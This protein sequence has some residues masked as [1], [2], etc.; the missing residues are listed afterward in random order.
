[1]DDIVSNLGLGFSVA[2][3]ANNLFFAFIGCLLGTL[4]GVLPGI[5][6]SATIAILLPITYT[7]APEA[8][9]IMMAGIY[10]G[11]QYGGSTTAIMIKLPGESS[12]IVTC[13][14]GYAMT[15]K[16]RSGPA[17]TAA[18]ISS[19]A[20]GCFGIAILILFAK[21]LTSLVFEFGAAEYFALMVLG[22]VGAV[23][24]SSSSGLSAIGMVIVGLLLGLVGTDVNTGVVR[25]GFGIPDLVDG[26]SFTV[27]AMG[28]F[29]YGEVLEQLIFKNKTL[30][31]LKRVGPL[32]P[33][34]Q[35][36]KDMVYPTLRGSAI[37]ALLGSLP[38][39]GSTISSFAAYAAE[40]R[41]P[42]Q[43]HEAPLGEGNIRGV[44][45]P[46]A[47]NNA[48][49]QTAFIPLLALG[50]PATASTALMLG[51]MMMH[52]IQ[53]G[54]QLMTGHPELFWGLIASM[55]VGNAV[56]IVLNIPL[57]GLW[58]WLLSIPYKVLAAAIFVFCAVGAYS[59]SNNL[60]DVLLLFCFGVFGLV[61]IKMRLDPTP[62]LLG[63]ILGP[64]MEENLRRALLLSRGD[65][66]VFVSG[67]IST[68]LLAVA[69]VLLI[70]SMVR[71]RG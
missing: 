25:Y 17:L 16:G 42:K 27:I 5:G 13:N 28:L 67:G 62:L 34:K 14:D 11:S 47:A 6:S 64:M 69:A 40:K 59:V 49:T 29:G 18:G 58:V 71:R 61:I 66:G 38:G 36:F 37:G 48:S 23:V 10:Y 21:P 19:F 8:A 60:F 3:G 9:L 39:G 46:E 63:C 12:S 43:P 15:L 57:V 68:G 41:V 70:G 52:G 65:W 30:P 20:G 33:T 24:L 55:F 7:L 1:M 32:M 54:P 2:F 51:A 56:L 45:A 50:I 35:D 22:L 4:V 53:P 31:R 26:F 44:A